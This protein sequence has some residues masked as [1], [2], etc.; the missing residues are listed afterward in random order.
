MKF[1]KQ[2]CFALSLLSLVAVNV[3]AQDADDE[4]IE[5]LPTISLK[6]VDGK[7]VNVA[8]YG[9]NNKITVFSFWATW[10]APCIAEMPS[11]QKLYVDYKDKV[12]FRG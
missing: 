6:N 9:E 12:R 10:C 5:R 8:D 1:L 7:Q 3:F 2:F 11:M 4:E